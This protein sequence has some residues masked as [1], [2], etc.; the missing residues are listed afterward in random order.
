M[1]AN[2]VYLII[3]L[4]FIGRGLYE[5]FASPDDLFR[6]AQRRARRNYGVEGGHPV[7]DFERRVRTS[8]FLIIIM[9]L[10]SVTLY[11]VSREPF[12]TLSLVTE[13]TNGVFA[14][15]TPLGR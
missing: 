12:S 9:G 15:L 4:I 14:T 11:F 5:L 6:N 1:N 3:G 8:A 10:V 13:P 2:L 7:R